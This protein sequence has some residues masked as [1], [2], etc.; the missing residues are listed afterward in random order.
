MRQLISQFFVFLLMLFFH[1]VQ[2]HYN[3]KNNPGFELEN[4]STINSNTTAAVF[5]IQTK[6]FRMVMVWIYQTLDSQDFIDQ[7]KLF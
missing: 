5:W 2:H 7:K 4:T 1:H 3:Y 6:L